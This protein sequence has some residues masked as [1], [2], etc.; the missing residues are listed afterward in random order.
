MNT[1]PA[2]PHVDGAYFVCPSI[3]FSFRILIG[4][5]IERWEDPFFRKRFENILNC[6]WRDHD[7][8]SL[9]GRLVRLGCSKFSLWQTESVQHSQNIPRVAFIDTMVH[10]SGGYPAPRM[11]TQ[12][13]ILR[14]LIGPTMPSNSKDICDANNWKFGKSWYI[15][16]FLYPQRCIKII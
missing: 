14:V 9:E 7:P 5:T 6:N 3:C 4:G 10:L 12:F 11:H 2:T 8:F 15:L 1:R 13:W 16:I